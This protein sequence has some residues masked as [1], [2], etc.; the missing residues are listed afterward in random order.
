LSKRERRWE[1]RGGL[2]KRKKKKGG[3]RPQMISSMS[4]TLDRSFLNQT[5]FTLFA[6]LDMKSIMSL[7]NTLTP[8]QKTAD[9]HADI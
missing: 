9:L 4:Y 5:T 6:F 8:G 7:S 2:G 1:K 3:D